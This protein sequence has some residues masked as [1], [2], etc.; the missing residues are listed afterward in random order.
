MSTFQIYTCTRDPQRKQIM[1]QERINTKCI[2]D[3]R[4]DSVIFVEEMAKKVESLK[5]FKEDLFIANIEDTF[6]ITDIHDQSNIL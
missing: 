4:H 5:N 3:R 6:S 2:Q 1:K